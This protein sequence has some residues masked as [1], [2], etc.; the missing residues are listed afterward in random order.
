MCVTCGMTDLRKVLLCKVR[1]RRVAAIH[2]HACNTERS[3]VQL[4][5]DR[6]LAEF[7]I[8]NLISAEAPNN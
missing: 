6:Q 7:N 2:L 1:L 3:G 4:S 5:C 8:R